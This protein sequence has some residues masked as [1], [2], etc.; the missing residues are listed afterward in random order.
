MRIKRIILNNGTEDVKIPFY[1]H[2]W[3][4]IKV[5]SPVSP[6]QVDYLRS[7]CKDNRTPVYIIVD[8]LATCYDIGLFGN[9]DI[10]KVVDLYDQSEDIGI[11]CSTMTTAREVKELIN[12]K[13]EY[14]NQK[15]AKKGTS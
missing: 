9:K 8:D 1:N 6:E 2:P 5:N 11:S 15:E 12:E 3:M 10:E 13:R 14:Y 4:Y 7:I